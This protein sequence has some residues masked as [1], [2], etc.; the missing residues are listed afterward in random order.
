M[1]IL[2]DIPAKPLAFEDL[3]QIV[4]GRTPK[5]RAQLIKT[6]RETGYL[7]DGVSLTAMS[8]QEKQT[9]EGR[10]WDLLASDQVYQKAEPLNLKLFLPRRVSVKAETARDAGGD[11]K[12]RIVLLEGRGLK[13][14][15][16]AKAFSTLRD[17]HPEADWWFAQGE[18]YWKRPLILLERDGWQ[19]GLLRG[20]LA[21]IPLELERN[22]S[23]SWESSVLKR[24]KGN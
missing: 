20:A 24:H 16:G 13:V 22:G 6:A 2:G 9:V 11:G 19:A 17:R 1:K 7:S 3:L 15:V 21:S 8:H 23:T 14:V 18:E 12:V 5:F 4:A 10:H